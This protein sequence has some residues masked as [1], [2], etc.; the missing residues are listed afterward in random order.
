[1]K[2]T[3]QVRFVCYQYNCGGTIT[4][5]HYPFSRNFHT[6]KEAK[7]FA[8]NVK[9]LC[10][11]VPAGT[12]EEIAEQHCRERCEFAGQYVH[13]G[14]VDRLIGIFKITEEPVNGC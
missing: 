9:R 3:Y 1:M 10:Q 14:Y 6:L 8:D 5:G 11:C 12:D 4:N 7:T 2:I 13:S